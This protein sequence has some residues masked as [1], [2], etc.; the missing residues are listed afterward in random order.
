M[1][2]ALA[3]AAALL[4]GACAVDVDGAPCAVSGTTRDCP[5]GQACGNDLRC[6]ARALACAA[7]RCTPGEGSCE[8]PT[9][10]EI[11]V[12]CSPAD[13][14]CGRWVRDDC[15]AG[16]LECGARSGGVACECPDYVGTVVAADPRGSPSRDAL[17]FPRGQAMPP[18]CRFGRLGDALAAAAARAPDAAT[19]VVH[20][21]AGEPAVF[22]TTTGEAWPLTVASNVE[23]VGAGAP[24]GPTIVRGDPGSGALV[25]AAGA[26]ERVRVERPAVI[27][28]GV[29]GTGIATACS[30]GSVP[31]LRGVEV[32]GGAVLDPSGVATAGLEAGVKVSGACGATL[33]AVAVAGAAGPALA[34]EPSGAATVTVRGGSYGGSVVG[35]SIAGS[36]KV[37][38]EPDPDTAASTV[39]AGNSKEGVLLSGSTTAVDATFDGV[40]VSGNGG[41]GLVV[42]VVAPTT[43]LN[44]RQ[45][46]I[47]VNGA[48]A[49]RIYG[50][51]GAQRAV[52]GVLFAQAAQFLEFTFGGNRIFAN[53][54]DQLTFFTS[55]PWS[56]SAGTCGPQTN[57]FRCVSE[58]ALALTVT[59]PGSVEAA[60][61]LWPGILP[62][63]WV[64][65]G[66]DPTADYCGAAPGVPPIPTCP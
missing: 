5:A 50:E 66:V 18:E 52:G 12:R 57:V 15:A 63:Q 16:A 14:V 11:A 64:S 37:T 25:E 7:S 6:S 8:G 36:G 2:R 35:V 41:T 45:C 47:A 58:G 1:E 10:K 39:V 21:V 9:A 59:P 13:P 27:D 38:V 29:R 46:D 32:D 54:G 43:R 56:I 55:G 51:S 48:T 34:L 42:W 60:Y 4:L 30:S 3:L 49:P 40:V 24:A 17:P 31:S 19:V 44:V 62:T 53:A 22:G 26:I 61:S 28:G 23:L 65:T 20:G 33:T